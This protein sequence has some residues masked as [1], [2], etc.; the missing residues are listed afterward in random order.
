MNKNK[1]FILYV[2]LF[3]FFINVISLHEL[4]FP[5][6]FI[7]I[8]LLIKYKVIDIRRIFL[9]KKPSTEDTI[10]V[11]NNTNSNNILNKLKNMSLNQNIKGKATGGVFLV[12]FLFLIIVI[13]INSIKIIPAGKTGVYQLF[14][15]VDKNELS[16]GIHFINPLA[17][18]KLMSTRI[19]EY[20][21]SVVTGEGKR[22]GDDSI[23]AYTKEGLNVALD[24]TVLYKLDEKK[25]SE[26]F[27]E[28]GSS[29][30]EKIIRP[31]I[32][33]SIR[34]IVSLYEAKD[35][36]SEKRSEVSVKLEEKIKKDVASK[37]II[38]ESI[39]LRHV[40]LPNKLLNSIQEKL[41][42][43]QESQKYDF[44]LTKERKEAERKII[45]AEGQR[46]SQKI[47][48]ESLTEKY[49]QYLFINELKERE[50][51]I[52]IPTDSNSGLPMFYNMNQ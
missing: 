15:K 5:I 1:K 19:E 7:I 46:D 28:L 3:I 32:R 16:S 44:L 45:E 38:I 20:T 34:E 36:Y 31:T 4:M 18:V 49:L 14:G 2:I 12:V 52:Y 10:K 39:L 48:N 43:E 51:T 23:S 41:A 8:A 33:S 30:E 27:L 22:V 24:V 37:G 9:N 17:S 21:M 47:I 11:V 26:V 35:I 50:G 40:H 13:L 29:Y 42:A 25:A 6:V